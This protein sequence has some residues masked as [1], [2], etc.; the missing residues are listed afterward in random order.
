M[1][2]PIKT[3]Q[4]IDPSSTLGT[5]VPT[6]APDSV[7]S[8]PNTVTPN[9]SNLSP[10]VPTP[11]TSPTSTPVSPAPEATP[12]PV[13]TAPK[14]KGEWFNH[15]LK[16]VTPQQ[17]VIR[18]TPDGKQTI[19][20]AR[21]T[22]SM[23]KMF[24]A[25]VMAGM[26]TPNKYVE[27]P[28]GAQRID[29]SST[30]AAFGTGAEKGKELSQSAQ[31][32]YDDMQTRKL[33]AVA[34]NTAAMH[35]Y[36]SMQQAQ[37]AAEKEGA[38]AEMTQTKNWQGIVDQNKS[39]IL[40]SA[41]DFDNNRN[42]PDAP[43]ARLTSGM[44]T[45][46][47]LTSPFKDKM[48]SQLMVQDGLRSVVDPSTGKT[49]SVP[50]WTVLNPDV[51]IKL[52]KE[53]VDRAAKINP[54]FANLYEQTN[55][56][57][58]LNLGRFAAVTHQ[59]NSVDH[60][61]DL[62]QSISDSK[63]EGLKALGIHG[64]VEGRLAAA[65][66]G[67]PSA[68]RALLDFESATAHGGDTAAQLQRLLAAD[69]GDAIFKALGTDRDKVQNYINDVTNRR[70]SAEALA[71]QGGMGE[72]APA[73]PAQTSALVNSIKGNPDLE[74]SD[75]TNLLADVPTA[76]KDG[77]ILMTQGQVEKL[78]ARLDAAVAMRA[79]IQEKNKLANGD[80]E[81][82]KRT[83]SNTI[84]GDVNDVT[85][86]VSMRGNAREN[87]INAIHDEAADRGLDTTQYGGSALEA[88]AN[89]YKD[90][91][92]GQKTPTGKQ[93]VSFDNY[94]GHSAALLDAEGRLESKTLGLTHS[95][96]LNMT[97]KEIGNQLTDDKDWSAY[98]AALEPVKHE[99]E[100]FLA[101]GYATKSEDVANMNAL[102]SDKLPLRQVKSVI[103]Q[104]ADTADVRLKGLGQ[105]YVNTMGTTY[106]HLMSTDA[107]NALKRMGIDSKALPFTQP[108]PR[109]WV[110]HQAT[111]MTDKNMARAYY[112][113][114]G[115]DRNAAVALA[116]NNG[117]LL[118]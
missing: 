78:T 51:D 87:A 76:G 19:T 9:P 70:A 94:L 21:T 105:A 80:P 83:A 85:K 63:D 69:G 95:P 8:I 101:A 53:A 65:V 42:T 50:T 67:N 49:H 97:L 37:F 84:E 1:P 45:E 15:I 118:Q 113:A 54:S 96:V 89:M 6:Q 29:P 24:M 98:T 44:T 117:W 17:P 110:N 13:A 116:K 104:L 58:R 47:L 22:P 71:K 27:G 68:M 25:S 99:I 41:D 48:T 60:A 3:A 52:N 107:Q 4:Q 86:I 92:G 90:Y 34:A 5:G 57:V 91:S 75:K 36:A 59:I 35:G 26:M 31:K 74:E 102:L 14:T 33:N 32:Q 88:K 23:A 73:N 111:Q 28:G 64:D 100:N 82:M 114:A 40:A 30:I 62:L 56:D 81:Q 66:R 39:T 109:G 7:S 93:L 43:K 2:D 115:N 12:S 10:V 72:K 79:G 112:Q 55:G 61:E 11:T 103:R 38:E 108:L 77:Q 106:P 46:E 20:D 18:T 16:A